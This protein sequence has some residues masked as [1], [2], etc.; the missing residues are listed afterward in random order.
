V[1]EA[2]EIIRRRIDRRNERMKFWPR[3]AIVGDVTDGHKLN[4]SFQCRFVI[5]CISQSFLTLCQLLRSMH[6]T[7]LGESIL[8]QTVTLFLNGMLVGLQLDAVYFE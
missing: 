8:D 5:D 6:L 4:E 3:T 1:R 7:G 2:N